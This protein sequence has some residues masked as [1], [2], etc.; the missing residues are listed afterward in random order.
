[1]SAAILTVISLAV[2][3]WVFILSP[4]K[5]STTNNAFC[6]V[7]QWAPHQ[8]EASDRFGNRTDGRLELQLF[9]DC[10]PAGTQVSF[11][12]QLLT[13]HYFPE[14]GIIT[15]NIESELLTLASGKY[16]IYLEVPTSTSAF[17]V[18][19][20]QFTEGALKDEGAVKTSDVLPLQATEPPILIAHAGGGYRQKRYRNSIDALNY[21]YGLGHRFFEVDFSWTRDGHLVGI[22][23]WNRTY[24][25]LFP[26]AA[27]NRIP[28]LATFRSLP[29]DGGETQITMTSLSEWLEMH[30]DAF[31]I[32]DIKDRNIVGLTYLKYWLGESYHQV[33]PQIYH[34]HNYAAVRN[35][36]FHSII[37]TLYQTENTTEEIIES[38]RQLELFAITIHP[39]RQDFPVLL[40][41][42]NEVGLFVYIHTVNSVVDY[43]RYREMGVDGLY[44]DFL[45]LNADGIVTA[46]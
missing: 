11:D 29:M 41:A 2:M 25:R 14:E 39:E 4:G 37:Y 12:G 27:H 43:Q 3:V 45:Y 40:Q 9:I 33:I 19:Y 17:L 7:T 44:T 8:T 5:I 26:T 24:Q 32:T 28:D 35:L 21:N 16:P 20:M 6:P 18:G 30:P 36:G 42:F 15:A 31:I 10:Y 13:T 23:N 1:M 22:H 38:I 34:A 46:Q